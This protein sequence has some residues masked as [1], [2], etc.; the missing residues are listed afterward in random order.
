M[1][2]DAFAML[3]EAAAGCAPDPDIWEWF[4][5]GCRRWRGGLAG[6]TLESALGL[7]HAGRM[8]RRNTALAAAAEALRGDR[9]ISDWDLAGELA[10]RLGRFTSSKLARYRRTGA[11][12]D[13]DVVERE[14]LAADLSGAP[15]TTSRKNIY[16][17]IAMYRDCRDNDSLCLSMPTAD[18]CITPTAER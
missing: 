14:L 12:A 9:A 6:I 4:C 13:F 11:A 5:H 18:D 2:R 1:T 3:A 8:R 16:R 17:V 10:V 7:D 15:P